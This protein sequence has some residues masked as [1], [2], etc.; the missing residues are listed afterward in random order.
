[1]SHHAL[2]STGRPYV[3]CDDP[4]ADPV[5]GEQRRCSRRTLG[6]R[7]RWTDGPQLGIVDLPNGWSVVP[8]SNDFDHGAVRQSLFDGTPI[9]PIAIHVGLRGD[10]HTCPAC[11]QRRERRIA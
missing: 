3:E 2:T 11:A 4:V 10:L 1:M 7:D 9:Q 6:R 8:Y 5:T